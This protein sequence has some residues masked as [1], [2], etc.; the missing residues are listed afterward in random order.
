MADG[1]ASSGFTTKMAILSALDAIVAE[2]SYEKASIASICEIA[3]VSR[4]TFYHHFKDKNSVLQWHSRI[5]YEMGIDQIG[6]SLGWLNGHMVTTQIIERYKGLYFLGGTSSEYSAV[7]PSFIRHRVDN[8]RET[9]VDFQHMRLTPLLDFQIQAMASVES[10]M[11]N[12]YYAN[13]LGMSM[14]EF[15]SSIVTLVPSE[16]Y[17]AT[18]IHEQK[19]PGDTMLLLSIIHGD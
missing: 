11:A 18:E 1:L 17:A 12:R 16:L 7:V 6:R 2:K 14:K 19:Y 4:S 10:A 9:I 15:C 5:A 3:K 13:E 8:L